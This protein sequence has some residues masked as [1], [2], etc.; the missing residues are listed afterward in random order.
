M[1]VFTKEEF[2]RAEVIAA[3]GETTLSPSPF[4]AVTIPRVLDDCNHR[5]LGRYGYIERAA[6]FDKSLGWRV[7]DPRAYGRSG[8]LLTA[9]KSEC[10]IYQKVPAEYALTLD[11]W[12]TLNQGA[13]IEKKCFVKYVVSSTIGELRRAKPELVRPLCTLEDAC[14]LE[15][16]RSRILDAMN[17]VSSALA[18]E[19]LYSSRKVQG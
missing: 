5:E 2:D 16:G 14:L 6:T 9:E 11:S 10:A 4:I 1:T 7:V 12:R 13:P 8:V 18:F 17:K 19:Y 15:R 3:I